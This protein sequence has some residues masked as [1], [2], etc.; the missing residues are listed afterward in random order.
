MKVNCNFLIWNLQSSL[1][2]KKI[3]GSLIASIKV[4]QRQLLIL[5]NTCEMSV[6]SIKSAPSQVD[7]SGFHE[8]KKN[9]DRILTKTTSVQGQGGDGGFYYYCAPFFLNFD[10]VVAF[11]SQVSVDNAA[12]KSEGVIRDQMTLHLS[13]FHT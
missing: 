9:S 8:P 1:H 6:K 7:D 11:Q 2:L 3:F 12:V 5:E 4:R 10:A 13:S